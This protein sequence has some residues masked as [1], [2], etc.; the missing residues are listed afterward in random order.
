MSAQGFSSLTSLF[1]DLASYDE[2]EMRMYAGKDSISYFVRRLMK[3]SWFS[4]M[5]VP[6]SNS[7]GSI[8]S[9][10][11][12]T[13]SNSSVP[14][15]E[16]N[17]T[18]SG[19]YMLN[20]WYRI[21]LGSVQ[22]CIPQVTGAFVANRDV[23][24]MGNYSIR[25]TRNLGHW[26]FNETSITFND[27][28]AMRMDSYFLDYWNAYTLPA[29][30]QSGYANMIG[31]I[32]E[33]TN[34]LAWINSFVSSPANTP[35][36]GT[37]LPGAVLNVPLPY[38]FFRDTGVT[39]PTAALPY[40]EMRIKTSTLN[41]QNLLIVDNWG[42]LNDQACPQGT[43]R[44]AVTSDFAN[45]LLQPGTQTSVTP[46]P[47]TLVQW[48]LYS[49]YAVVS[50]DER[51]RMGKAPRDILIEQVQ[52]NSPNQVTLPTV[53]T[54]PPLP[55]L[56]LPISQQGQISFKLNFSNAV[57]AIFFGIE[58]YTNPA[59]HA[60]YTTV[61]PFPT[62]T[63]VI[64]TPMG[65]NAAG[66]VANLFSDPVTGVILSYE[67]SNRSQMPVDY[68]SLVAPFYHAPSIPMETGYHLYPY[69]VDLYAIDPFGSTNYGKLTNVSFQWNL[70]AELSYSAT[71]MSR[72]NA[73]VT[74]Q[75]VTTTLLAYNS[76]GAWNPGLFRTVCLAI[77]HNFVRIAGGALGD[78]CLSS[79]AA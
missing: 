10:S 24:Q 33:L 53:G 59:E 6:Q 77:N 36:A 63:G 28:L 2:L 79:C 30:K 42:E 66:N 8:T 1:I 76:T 5:P 39:L 32:P 7:G 47:P 48:Q 71:G 56:P 27:L 60:N 25:W 69:S 18:R 67:G 21:Q 72:L 41:W 38:G 19:D 31:N 52:T 15:L 54:L 22:A 70:A 43:S 3:S 20:S 49:T 11:F 50:N 14:N 55:P 74:P 57:K 51:K 34:P 4:I 17:I 26:I 29:G 46:V 23:T 44:A 78:N 73:T 62:S 68:Y 65:I 45:S 61:S 58:N 35:P 75:N 16:H 13:G 37:Y 64:F 12:S 40:N 9:T